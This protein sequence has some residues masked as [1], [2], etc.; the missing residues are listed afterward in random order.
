MIKIVALGRDL[1]CNL[2]VSMARRNSLVQSFLSF[3]SFSLPPHP[4]HYNIHSACPH[5]WALILSASLL[6]RSMAML[7]QE[8]RERH[9]RGSPPKAM[10]GGQ[11]AKDDGKTTIRG[12]Q[13]SQ[14]GADGG[15]RWAAATGGATR[16]SF[17][18]CCMCAR[19]SCARAPVFLLPSGLVRHR[20]FRVRRPTC[21]R[22]VGRRNGVLS[23]LV[24]SA[25]R[26][27]SRPGRAG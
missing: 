23:M 2:Q 26:A 27:Q 12:S 15:N 8:R 6:Y 25:L 13:G 3:L 7:P 10:R 20:L 5:T 21:P 22:A 4:T 18:F 14:K 1:F 11:K 24:W 19:P 9:R 17:S 16:T